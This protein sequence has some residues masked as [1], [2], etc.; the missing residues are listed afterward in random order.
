[1]IK[2]FIDMRRI[3]SLFGVLLLQTSSDFVPIFTHNSVLAAFT[4]LG[5]EQ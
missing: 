5:P 1:M 2:K 3:L 4:A